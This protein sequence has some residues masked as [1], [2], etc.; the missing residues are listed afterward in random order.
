[1]KKAFLWSVLAAIAVAG[2]VMPSQAMAK[3]SAVKPLDGKT[4]VEGR[5]GYRPHRRNRGG[6]HFWIGGGG[7]RGPTYYAPPV[8]YYAP[9][10][11]VYAPPTVMYTTPYYGGTVIYHR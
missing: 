3:E 5:R 9:P 10:P 6:G 1:M 8:R 7:Y 11:V 4:V 2:F